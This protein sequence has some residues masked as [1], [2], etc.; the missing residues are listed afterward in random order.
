MRHLNQV[1]KGKMENVNMKP[2][3]S[4]QPPTVQL[5]DLEVVP[6][7]NADDDSELRALSID[8][9]LSNV[10]IGEMNNFNPIVSLNINNC[11]RNQVHTCIIKVWDLIMLSTFVMGNLHTLKL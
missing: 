9:V 8:N 3:A 1:I 6:N 10:T 5:H 7:S 4:S 11:A 2:L